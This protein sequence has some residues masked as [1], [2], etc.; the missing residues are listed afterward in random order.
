MRSPELHHAPDGREQAFPLAGSIASL[1]EARWC[2][3]VALGPPAQFRDAPFRL[4]PALVL[5]D[6]TRGR[7]SVI[8]LQDI[9]GNLLDTL[10][11]PPSGAGS[12]SLASEG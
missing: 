10:R 7:A 2:E 6:G 1:P 11:D 12:R 8:H 3:V 4:D 5:E 9:L